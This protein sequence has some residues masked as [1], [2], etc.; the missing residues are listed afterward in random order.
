MNHQGWG[1][2]RVAALVIGMAG[3]WAAREARADEWKPISPEELKMTS[4]AEAPG[5]PAVFLYRQVDR[6]DA[7]IQRGRGAS[8]FNYSRIKILTEEGRKYATIEIPFVKERTNISGIHARTINPDGSVSN[9][10][11]KIYDQVVEKTKG[12]KYLAKTFTM[13][14]VQ[15]GSIIEYHYNIDLEDYFIFRS[16]WILSEELFTKRADFTLKPYNHYPWNVQWSWPAGLPKGT[17]P[18]KEGPDHI[19][20]MSTENVPAFV[21]EDHMPPPNELKYRVV[22]IYRDEPFDNDVDKYWKQFGKKKAGQIEGFVDKKK[23]MDEAVAGIVV[24]SDA[25]EA[26][27]RKIYDRVQQ[28][29]N[30]SYLPAKSEEQRKQE[31]IKENKDVEELWKHQ[32]GSGWDLTWLFLGLVRSAGFEAYP[33]LVSGRSEYFFRKERVNGAELDANVVQVKV[34]GQDRY[35]DPGA[36][37]TPFGILPWVETGVIGMRLDKN[38]GTWIQTTLP[39]S[40]DAQ[41]ERS[42]RLKLSNEGDLTGTVKV[43]YTGLEALDRRIRQRNEDDT[44]RKKNLEDEVK[45]LIPAGSEVELTNSPDW[46][47]GNMPL[48]AEFTL[49]VPGWISAAGRRAM[50]PTGLFSASEKHLFEH[51]N[52]VWPVYFRYAFRT[53]DDISVDLPEGWKV[54]SA[55]KDLD[56]DAKAVQ[57]KLQIENGGN[58][59][60]IQRQL[61]SDVVMVDKQDYAVLRSFY[62]LVKTE[63]EQQI[64]LQPGGTSAAN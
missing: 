57:Y 10:D 35:F 8:E 11:G 2:V 23:A 27:L 14:N 31:N 51:A 58:R 46:K 38:G 47:N 13:P 50:L 61:R 25:P 63:D 45:N 1:R 42:A 17:E 32:Y 54:E 33:C 44:E 59:V 19:I 39:T 60:R 7:G 40:Q 16:Y 6:N 34:N 26:K 49:K 62:Q 37:F 64:V 3:L 56:R 20:R 29:K 15:V 48:V 28:I 22:F 55:P 5:A 53:A 30:L 9:F 18:P 24:A 36:A 52:R 12:V 21:E 41:V 43:T 4:L